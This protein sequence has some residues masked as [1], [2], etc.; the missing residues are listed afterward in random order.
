MDQEFDTGATYLGDVSAFSNANVAG[1]EYLFVASAYDA[2]V[3]SYLIGSNG[4]LSLA[5]TV[6]PGEFSG[7]YLAQ[8]LISLE[9]SAKIIW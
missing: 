7:F 3:S 2:G 4:A 8:D 5:D 9:V 1:V 6:T